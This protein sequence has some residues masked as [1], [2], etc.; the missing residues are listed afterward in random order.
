MAKSAPDRPG[1]EIKINEI[2]AR[3][4]QTLIRVNIDWD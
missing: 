2:N 1:A 3:R 4:R